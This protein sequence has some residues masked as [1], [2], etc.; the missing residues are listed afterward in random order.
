M[1]ALLTRT[2]SPP[3]RATA[4]SIPRPT[5][6]RL[7]TSPGIASTASGASRDPAVCAS[8]SA[9]RAMSATRA[10]SATKRRAVAAPIPV[11][12]PVITATF[13][14]RRSLTA[15]GS[16]PL[17][18]RTLRAVRRRPCVLGLDVGTAALRGALHD[19][20]SGDLVAEASVPLRVRGRG[21]ARELDFEAVW[22]GLEAVLDLLDV[23]TAG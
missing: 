12:A 9:S 15:R 13:P 4:A 10:P 7:E 22:H 19:E 8:R 14:A 18:K 6:S 5:C 17:S 21:G 23:R 16:S 3:N 1:P 2:S 11:L 20:R